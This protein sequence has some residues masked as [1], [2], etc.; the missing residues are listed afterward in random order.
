MGEQAIQAASPF[1]H[2]SE[3]GIEEVAKSQ[4]INARKANLEYARMFW[5]KKKINIY[6]DIL[7]HDDQAAVTKGY[8]ESLK[9]ISIGRAYPKSRNKILRI[10]KKKRERINKA[11]K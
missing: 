10:V 4:K 1:L 2:L 3:V 8:R 5:T 7:I 11:R 6:P 9:K